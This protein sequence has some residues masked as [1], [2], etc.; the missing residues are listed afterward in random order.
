MQ[1]QST[2]PKQPKLRAFGQKSSR[3][4]H[5]GLSCQESSMTQAVQ[6]RMPFVGRMS[7]SPSRQFSMDD[8]PA[9]VQKPQHFSQ[10]VAIHW[11]CAPSIAAR[12]WT[13][14]CS[15]VS[16]CI[17]T[18]VQGRS[19]P[20]SYSHSCNAS[21]ITAAMKKTAHAAGWSPT[22][23]PEDTNDG[24]WLFQAL[25][26]NLQLT[27]PGSCVLLGCQF[28]KWHFLGVCRKWPLSSFCITCPCL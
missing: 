1:R 9:P 13:C 12:P 28:G 8:L 16:G 25:L 15:Q 18:P 14:Q 7:S 20:C 22:C 10:A 6:A 4:P 21:H 11:H 3:G 23:G 27:C 19:R 2:L 17:Y 24:T 26:H 5:R